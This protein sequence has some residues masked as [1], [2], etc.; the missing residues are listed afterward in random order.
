MRFSVRYQSLG[1][2]PIPDV[3]TRCAEELRTGKTML[4]PSVGSSI[5]YLRVYQ[6]LDRHT[7]HLNTVRTLVGRPNQ[8]KPETGHLF[9]FCRENHVRRS[10]RGG[11]SMLSLGSI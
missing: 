5:L 4:N 8:V 9:G 10:F 2:F 11:L 1:T 3:S 6:H 7:H